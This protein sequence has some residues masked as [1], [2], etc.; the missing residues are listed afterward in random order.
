MFPAYLS[1]FGPGAMISSTPR[2]KAKCPPRDVAASFSNVSQSTP[3]SRIR[4]STA[5]DS[6]A[7]AVSRSFPFPRLDRWGGFALRIGF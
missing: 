5:R 2:S 4:C 3:V 7:A 1:C 6:V